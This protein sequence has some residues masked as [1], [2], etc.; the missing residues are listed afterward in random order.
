MNSYVQLI[1]LIFSFVYGIFLFYFNQ[2]N[3]RIF[4]NK[5]IILKVIG[6]VLYINNV[7]LLYIY[8]LYKINYGILH[9][10]FILLIVLGYFYSSVKKRK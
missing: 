10:Y 8:F 3:Y 7:T 4:Q 6:S 1:C 9:I 2:F 5:N